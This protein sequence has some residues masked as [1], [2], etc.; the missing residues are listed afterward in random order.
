VL[1]EI[2][3]VPGFEFDSLHMSLANGIVLQ[4]VPQPDALRFEAVDASIASYV[5]EK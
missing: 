2:L 4:R 3:P 1:E 5:F